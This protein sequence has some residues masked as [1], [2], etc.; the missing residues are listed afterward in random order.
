VGSAQRNARPSL[1]LKQYLHF[2]RSGRTLAGSTTLVD[3]PLAQLA[4]SGTL[5]LVFHS[6]CRRSLRS[7]KTDLV[8][9]LPRKLAKIAAGMAGLRV[10]E[11]PRESRP[12]RI[13]WPGIRDLQRTGARMFR[14][15]LR[16]AAS[17]NLSNHAQ[18]A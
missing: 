4:R 14:E 13:S 15:Q 10:V 1:T 8:L 18:E 12:F 17:D 7:L 3:R 5:C 9:T 2:P 11:P 6:L 16:I